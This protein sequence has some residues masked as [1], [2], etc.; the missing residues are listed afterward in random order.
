ML[1]HEKKKLLTWHDIRV[2]QCGQVFPE[3]RNR[4]SHWLML[5][6][7][8]IAFPLYIICYLDLKLSQ[9]WC[10]KVSSSI[11]RVCISISI[12]IRLCTW[13]Q[14]YGLEKP[15]AARQYDTTERNACRLRLKLNSKLVHPSLPIIRAPS[16][17]CI[18]GTKIWKSAPSMGAE[19]S[20]GP[21]PSKKG[22]RLQKKR[23]KWASRT[24]SQ[25]VVVRL[26]VVIRLSYST[27]YTIGTERTITPKL[28]S[29]AGIWTQTR[30]ICW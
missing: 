20:L 1:L 18:S 26:F 8:R 4:S 27:M 28:W 19:Q 30:S 25:P 11:L 7:T 5:Q 24:T 21:S 6:W 23:E 22:T 14:T 17:P 3:Y 13:V 2:W 12:Q 29:Y 16:F 15:R 9:S 10:Q